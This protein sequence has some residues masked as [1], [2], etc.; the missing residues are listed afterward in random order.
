MKSRRKTR[1][2]TARRRRL[3]RPAEPAPGADRKPLL[4]MDQAI[5]LLKTSRSTFYRWLRTGK[6][7]G[8]KVGRQWRFTR[9]DIERFLRGQEPRVDLPADIGPLLLAL[10]ERLRAAGREPP[11]PGKE[12]DLPNGDAGVT[13]AVGV[14]I[15]LAVALGASDLH[16]IAAEGDV[17]VRYRLDGALR[18]VA[19]YDARLHPALIARWKTMAACDPLEKNLPQDGRIMLRL[20]PKEDVADLRLNFLPAVF[21]EG[22]TM[23]VLPRSEVRF[24]FDRLDFLPRD[25]QLILKWIGSPWGIVLVTGP[26]G[27]GKTTTVYACLAHLNRPDLKVMTVEDPVEYTFAGMVQVPVRP[28]EGLTFARA[29][30]SFL[31]AD[32]DVIMVGEVRDLEVLNIL[33][34]AA[35][36]GHLVFSTLHTNDAAQALERMLHMGIEA[37]LAAD[38]TK[39][40]VAQRLVRL[41]CR[42]CSR[43]AEPAPNMVEHLV[44][45]ARRGGVEWDALEKRCREPVG[46]PRCKQ[47]GFRGRTLIA[48]ALEVT[49]EIG[50]ALR[51]GASAD[52]LRT[53]AVGQG[54]KTMAA[55]GILRAAAGETTLAEVLRVAPT[56]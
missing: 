51:R 7:K 22:L 20:A 25:K 30:R 3:G 8:M 1:K 28:K 37:F 9:E 16:L 42:E 6:V 10:E 2:P 14:M 44:Q 24:G 34:Q 23:R 27:C 43:P 29:V 38:A 52:E 17:S 12:A 41:L 21:G 49:P 18:E 32:P 33:H 39:L 50:A 45:L 19:R 4:T 5:G 35:L 47:T 54:M 15:H 13:R 46:C 53:I 31:R 56:L 26:A 40:I 36:T 55:H 48:E 11:P